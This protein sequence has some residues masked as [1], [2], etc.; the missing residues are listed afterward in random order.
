MAAGK[1]VNAKLES[2]VGFYVGDICYELPREDYDEIWGNQHNYE[3]GEYEV[4]DSKFAVGGTA[5]GDGEYQDQRGHSYGVDAGVI[6]IIPYELCKDKDIT[7]LNQMGRFVEAKTAQFESDEGVFD[8][9]FDNGFNIHIDTNAEEEDEEDDY[10]DDYEDDY[11]D[12]DEED[13]D[14]ED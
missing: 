3:D 7:R 13:Y 14:D 10:Y 11:D 8:I 5:Y 2:K 6:G 4:R 9:D 12:E 1:T